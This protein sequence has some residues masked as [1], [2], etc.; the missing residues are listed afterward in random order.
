MLLGA[1]GAVRFSTF[2]PKHGPNVSV[3]RQIFH[4]W[5]IWDQHEANESIL[6]LEKP[7][8]PASFLRVTVTHAE[9][10]LSAKA[11]LERS[12]QKVPLEIGKSEMRAWAR[13]WE[14]QVLNPM[15]NH[16]RLGL[17]GISVYHGLF[18]CVSY[19]GMF[20]VYHGISWYIHILR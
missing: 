8:V 1:R 16:L 2:R 19:I 5:S 3:R 18:T 14:D 11:Q 10:G 15:T 7:R 6:K 13:A 20:W 9:A 12:L 17:L 4:T